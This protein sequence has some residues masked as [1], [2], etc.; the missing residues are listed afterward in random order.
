MRQSVCLAHCASF[1]SPVPSLNTD[2]IFKIMSWKSTS[3]CVYSANYL[4]LMHTFPTL[5]PK[6]PIFCVLMCHTYLS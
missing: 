5:V 4:L 1:R 3:N 2:T 6:L